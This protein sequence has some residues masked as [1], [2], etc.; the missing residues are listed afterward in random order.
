M[1]IVGAKGFAK[2]VLEICHNNKLLESLVFFDD[3]TEEKQEKLFGEFEILKTDKSVK[4]FFNSVENSFAIGI[5]NPTLRLKMYEKFIELGGGFKSLISAKANIG[6]Y[7][8]EIDDGVILMD[9]VNVSNS[10]SIGKGSMIYYNSNITHDCK[11]GEFV[12]IAPSVS[13]LGRVIVGDFC[14]IGANATVLPDVILGKHV[15][16]GAGAV[17]TKNFPDY[18]VIAGVPAKLI[19]HK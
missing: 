6:S 19:N 3:V 1:L 7:D 8:V 14:R 11:I 9:G 10:V 4:T 15:T 13:V 12:E 18:S 2:E 16:V 17:V 5:G